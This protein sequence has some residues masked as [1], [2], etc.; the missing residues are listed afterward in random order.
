MIEPAVLPDGQAVDLPGIVPRLSE[1]PGRTDWV[2][3][4]L[5][6]HV[7]DVLATLGFDAGALEALRKE[8][9]I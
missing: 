1:T 9:V 3:P 6:A 8:R 2:G 5:G 4:A 7:G